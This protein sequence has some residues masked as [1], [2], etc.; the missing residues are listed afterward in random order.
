[1]A[2]GG[3]S[4]RVYHSADPTFA[5][6]L[7]HMRKEQKTMAEKMEESSIAGK[8]NIGILVRVKRDTADLPQLASRLVSRAQQAQTAGDLDRLINDAM[9]LEDRLYGAGRQVSRVRSRL[10][11]VKVDLLPR[12]EAADE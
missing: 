7:G 6:A 3:M 5:E 1:M 10:S 8:E 4:R 12:P 11:A 9:E 2:K